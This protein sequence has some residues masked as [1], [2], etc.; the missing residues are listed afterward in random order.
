MTFSKDVRWI[1]RFQNYKRAFSLLNQTLEDES[2]D[3]YSELECCGI[4][5]RFEFTFELGWKTFKDY[6][7]YSG[8]KVEE[9]TPRKV[10]KEC[11][12]NGIFLSASVNPEVYIKMMLERNALSH[13]YDEER[14]N[15]ALVNIKDIYLKELKKQYDFFIAKEK[16]WEESENE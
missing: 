7:E 6:L 4:I 16:E 2:T 3:S 8:I 5:Q 9:S 11:A 10:I 12:E 14:F 15:S 1:Q 13:V